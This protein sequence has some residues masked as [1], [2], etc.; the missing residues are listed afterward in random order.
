[1]D[2]IDEKLLRLL[3][4]YNSLRGTLFLYLLLAILM[5]VVVSM[6]SISMIVSWEKLIIENDMRFD[7]WF[8][9]LTWQP[10]SS[11][12][13]TEKVAFQIHLLELLRTICPFIY[14]TIAVMVVTE[15]FYKKKIQEPLSF[16]SYHI[17][18]M[19]EGTFD[20][21]VELM[22]N[23][24]FEQLG[25][26]FDELRQT[27]AIQQN[28]ILQLHTEQ[29]KINAAFSHDIRTPLAIIQN[30]AELIEE[31]I[32]V[33]S[34]PLLEKSLNKIQ[35]N[36]ERLTAFSS[37]MQEIQKLEELPINKKKIEGQ[38]FIRLLKNS[39]ETFPKVIFKSQ[40][41]EN[42]VLLLDSRVI[43]EALENVLTNAERFAIQT[44]DVEVSL[45][46]SYLN[47]IVKDD[48]PGFSKEALK[49][50]SDPYFSQ[51]KES[52]F[53][54]GLTI[55]EVLTQKHG[56]VLKLGN[57]ANGGAIVTLVFNV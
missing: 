57:G 18:N 22:T 24:D 20:Q 54:L 40:L 42:R 10:T 8:E 29:K 50:A 46:S 44:I 39:V 13:L 7:K 53:G 28:E 41:P 16:L 47:V 14:G 27:L 36:V 31:I 21:P 43:V 37:T 12:I 1:M 34:N 15:K 26:K 11:A 5:T 2:W 51:N 19:Q 33:K 55:C 4:K 23:D 32:E 49:L 9:F 56:G 17:Q 30:N 45:V 6:V 35:N 38:A 25:K 48:G 52:H 3:K